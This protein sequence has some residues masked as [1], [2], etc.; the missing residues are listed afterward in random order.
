MTVHEFGQELKE[1]SSKASELSEHKEGTVKSTLP[2]VE[3][4][5]A[6]QRFRSLNEQLLSLAPHIAQVFCC[7]ASMVRFIKT[8]VE[9]AGYEPEIRDGGLF[10]PLSIEEREMT[11]DEYFRVDEDERVQ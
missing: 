8:L 7:E 10:Y 5:E 9:S 4:A 3:T 11:W 2:S 6:I 1:V